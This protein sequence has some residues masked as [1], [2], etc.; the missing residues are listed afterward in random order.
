[1]RILLNGGGA[2]NKTIL[3]NK[4]LNE[5]IDH[6]KPILYIPLAMEEDKYDGCYEWILGELKNVEVPYIEMVRSGKEL[7]EKM[8]DNYSAV[9][10]G[11]G[12][13]FKLLSDLKQNDIFEKLMNY[14]KNNGVVF[15]G[16][17]GTIIFGE[18][19]ESCYLDDTN[20]VEL[21]D[22]KG[23]NVLNGVS[24]LCHYTNRTE[25][26]DAESTK[27]LLELSK[28]KKIIALPEEDTLYIN[29]SKIEVIGNK[30][31]YIFESGRR[32]EMNTNN[33]SINYFCS[34]FDINNAFWNELAN[35]IKADL[36]NTNRIIYIP[37]S[38][39]EKKLEKAKS[40]YIPA[41]TEHFKKIGIEFANVECITPDMS[42]EVAQ[43]LVLDSDMVFL[44]GG[45]PF[46]QQELYNSK[47]LGPI[48]QNYNGVIMGMSA[49]AMNMSKNI[50]I[51]PRSEE[52]SDFDIRPGLNLSNIS[53]YP[54]NN[55]EG[56]IFPE[57]VDLGGEIT[58]SKDLIKVAYEY[59]NFYCLQDYLDGNGI[60]HV[61]LI[62]TCG[63]DIR[64]F[65]NNDGKAWE[66]S[67]DGFRL[68]NN[69]NIEEFTLNSTD[70]KRGGL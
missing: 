34:G 20:G 43:I 57:Q 21:N 31:W 51:T 23:F 2:G 39:K 69:Q 35:Q 52:Y 41:F 50:I 17:A 60:V 7:S 58:K 62:R 30:P 46:L 53:I 67:S 24:F 48:L 64:L 32:I 49:G 33:K 1:M 10:I 56:T 14:I 44:L 4:K 40:V 9:F 70:K 28:R 19:L 54:H 61:S 29:D 18:D 66:V 47:G 25:K 37:G 12:N 3:A 15:G 27:Y 22:I 42:E 63:D 26:K 38:T 5:V 13:T 59:G 68:I 6:T 16:S 8:L 45:N 36:K 55:F 11:G 65:T